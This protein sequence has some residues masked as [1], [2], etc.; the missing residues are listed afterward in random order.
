MGSPCSAPL[1]SAIVQRETA[2]PKRLDQTFTSDW[3]WYIMKVCLSTF[4]MSL[5]QVVQPMSPKEMAYVRALSVLADNKDRMAVMKDLLTAIKDSAGLKNI[6]PHDFCLQ[7]ADR[8]Q[9]SAFVD[10]D[11]DGLAHF[12]WLQF[13]KKQGSDLDDAL[14]NISKVRGLW[15]CFTI[16]SPLSTDLICR[17][18]S[19][20]SLRR[21]H[22]Q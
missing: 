13:H 3:Y 7:L 15:M 8:L 17:R 10:V 20:P 12:E 2:G 22:M 18:C 4:N 5:L 9:Y 6:S 19:S 1:D 14:I 16:S 11:G 21:L